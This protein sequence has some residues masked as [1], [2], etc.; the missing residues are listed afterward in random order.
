MKGYRNIKLFLSFPC[1]P[2]NK[3]VSLK[4]VVQLAFFAGKRV[5]EFFEVCVTDRMCVIKI[6]M[7]VRYLANYFD[8]DSGI[9]SHDEECKNAK[10]LELSVAEMSCSA[11]A[12]SCSSCRTRPL[13]HGPLL[14]FAALQRILA[15]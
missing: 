12:Y 6:Y 11:R 3:Y 10:M 7:V 14:R 5:W 4:K 15:R 13:L 2:I 8:I 1:L 9:N